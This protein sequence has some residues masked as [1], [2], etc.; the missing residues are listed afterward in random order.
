MDLA[1]T[2]QLTIFGAIHYVLPPKYAVSQ[3]LTNWQIGKIEKK[4]L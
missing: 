1:I 2:S 3:L 4:I